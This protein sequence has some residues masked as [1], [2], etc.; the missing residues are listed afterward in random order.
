M[1][2]LI[3]L[4]C[5]ILAAIAAG[6]SVPQCTQN[7]VRANSNPVPVPIASPATFPSLIGN[8]SGTMTGYQEDLGFT[9]YPNVTLTM[10]VLEQDGR[11]FSGRLV[12]A[13]NGNVLQTKSF[14]GVVDRDNRHIT[15]VEQGGG[16]DTGAIIGTDEIE[17]TYQNA[18]T[19]YTISVD[20]LK[21]A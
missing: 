6:C 4:I 1:R 7:A 16:Y 13:D 17:L 11:I 20:T 18:G 9:S 5:L 19:P 21:R 3:C 2:S 15:M 14:A 8:W 10:A 12:F